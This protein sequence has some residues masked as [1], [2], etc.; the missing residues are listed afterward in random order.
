M[1][2]GVRVLILQGRR[3]ITEKN[4][5]YFPQT[6][7]LSAP[8]LQ[9]GVVRRVQL[10]LAGV[11]AVVAAFG[12]YARFAR[13]RRPTNPPAAALPASAKILLQPFRKDGVDLT[14][15]A[16]RDRQYRIAMQAGATL[17]YSWSTSR[18]DVSYQFADQHP[19][20]GTEAHGAFVAQSSGWY[21]W[22]WN[23]PNG[24]PVTIHINLR[25]YYEPAGMPYD[26]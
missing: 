19:G 9:S 14:V 25:G 4:L 22:H 23:N 15:E 26:R 13:V 8:A 1:S 2:I 18:G 10:F 24:Y 16:G 6:R 21:R 12:L 7:F 5:V 11:L 17:V 3:V 20:H